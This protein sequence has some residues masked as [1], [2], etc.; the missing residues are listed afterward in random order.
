[1]QYYTVNYEFLKFLP[2]WRRWTMSFNSQIDFGDSLGKTT[3]LPPYLNYFAGGPDTI[4]G[5]RESRLGPK[6][7][8]RYY[9]SRGFNYPGNPY[10][11]NLRVVGRAE[12][13]FPTPEK[14]RSS[15]RISW[16]YDIGNVYQTNNNI[17]FFDKLGDPINYRFKYGNLKR[18]TGIAVQWLAPLGV[19]RFSFAF[20]LNAG[21]GDAR[22]YEDEQERFQFSIGQAF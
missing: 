5:Y 7:S 19:F 12:L 2:I 8:N 21:K 1:V 3:A 22:T 16:F 13:L 10:G 6:D 18:S 20:P 4:R 15:A 17:K 9:Q 11:G 14:W